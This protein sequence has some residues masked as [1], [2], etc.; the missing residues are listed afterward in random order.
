MDNPF[1][2]LVSRT[3]SHRVVFRLAKPSDTTAPWNWT[4]PLRTAFAPL[5]Y[6]WSRRWSCPLNELTTQLRAELYPEPSYDSINFSAYRSTLSTSDNRFPKHWLVNLMN[7]LSVWVYL[8]LL[9]STSTKQ[10]AEERAW[11]FVHTEDEN[12]NYIG[13]TIVS[14]AANLVATYIREGEDGESV[15]KHR[16]KQSVY[17]FMTKDGMLINLVDGAQIWDIAQIVQTFSAAGLAND[18]GYRVLLQKSLEFLDKHQ[19]QDNVPNQDHCF[20]QHRK[21][22]WGIG[23]K[24]QGYMAAEATSEA[25]RSV[26]LLQEE[27]NFTRLISNDRLQDVVDC[28][29]L[30]QNDTGGFCV[31]E[32]RR[33]GLDLEWMESSEFAGKSVVSYDYVECAASVLTSLALFQRHHPKYRADDIQHAIDLGLKYIRTAQDQDGGWWALWGYCYV[34][35][36][37]WALECL[38]AFDESYENS[39]HARRGCDFLVSKQ[40]DDGGWGESYK[41]LEADRYVQQEE[42]QTVQTAWACLALLYAQYPDGEVVTRG[43]KLLMQ[44]QSA[45][46]QW[47]RGQNES[48]VGTG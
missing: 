39:A 47:V 31:Y 34:Y 15:K 29:L 19:L 17:P 25:L 14:S 42:S 44:R 16:E 43:I 12:T 35:G 28:M 30:L 20:R 41:S 27:H 37:M 8:P 4:L 46:G 32:K 18:P 1:S 3:S 6:V 9:R 11:E 33:G 22:G 24:E 10:Q 7:F 38:A 36:A 40:K 5:S 23:V 2:V 26:L 48:G 21:G 45:K 13:L